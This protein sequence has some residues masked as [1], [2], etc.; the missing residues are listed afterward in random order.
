MG[1]TFKVIKAYR[2]LLFHLSASENPLYLFYYKRFFKP[3]LGSL[4]EVLDNFSKQNSPTTFLQIGAND[5]FNGDPIHKFIKRDNWSGILLE[6]QPDVYHNWLVKIHK[7]RPEIKT[8]NA[9]LDEKDGKRILYKLAIS[10]ERWASGLSSFDKQQLLSKVTHKRFLKHVKREGIIVPERENDLI[11]EH[12]I[13][14]ISP[15]TLFSKFGDQ[16]INIVAIDTEGYD[17]E[18]IKMLDITK[19]NPDI[20][21]YEDENLKQEAA[22][23]CM[24]YLC[25]NGYKIT[26]IRKD[27]IAI[28]IN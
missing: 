25:D 23:E 9:A 12:E 24:K 10:N 21:L 13:D 22:K 11:V 3:R 16:R 7:K 18:I 27:V 8:I 6:P 4:D 5:G 20:I 2:K 28:K 15:E 14:T 1:L 19:I 26:T 17:F